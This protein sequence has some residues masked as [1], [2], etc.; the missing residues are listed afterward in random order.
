M[1]EFKSDVRKFLEKHNAELEQ[2][3]KHIRTAFVE[4]MNKELAKQLFKTVG[5]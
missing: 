1:Y 3:H 2:K 4:A 5:V